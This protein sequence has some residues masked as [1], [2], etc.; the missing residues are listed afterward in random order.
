MLP[1]L[2]LPHPPR[3]LGFWDVLPCSETTHSPSFHTPV[4]TLGLANNTAVNKCPRPP[5]FLEAGSLVAQASFQLLFLLPLSFPHAGMQ[6]SRSLHPA[7]FIW[8]GKK[9]KTVE[10]PVPEDLQNIPE[11]CEGCAHAHARTFTR[12]RLIKEDTNMG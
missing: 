2:F 3:Q 11:E 8:V 6:D 4:D 1:R 5:L 12:M 10:Y 7:S 9:D